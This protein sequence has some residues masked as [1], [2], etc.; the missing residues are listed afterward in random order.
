MIQNFKIYKVFIIIGVIETYVN[1]G[2]H[3]KEEDRGEAVSSVKVP[4]D[5]S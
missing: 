3:K 5:F 2:S 1:V 4:G